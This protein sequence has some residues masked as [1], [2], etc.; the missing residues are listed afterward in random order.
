[1][2]DQVLTT[3]Q[4]AQ[5]CGVNYRTVIRWIE[6][7]EL[8]AYR[9]PGRGDHRVQIPD[10]VDFL[11]RHGMPIPEDFRHETS[12]ALVVDDDPVVSRLIENT[13]RE[14]QLEV[15][16]ADN[17]FRAG[18]LLSGFGPRLMTLDLEM[19]GLGGFEVLE[20]VRSHEEFRNTKVLV[21]SGLPEA[22]LRRAEEKGAHATLGKPVQVQALKDITRQLL[23]LDPSAIR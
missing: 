20:I 3:G 8:H 22:E 2:A 13:L 7:G 17:G 12:R 6:R 21:I 18:A 4:V 15:A 10:F 1:M 11:T 23:G 16:V 5:Y 19:P 9:L 14:L